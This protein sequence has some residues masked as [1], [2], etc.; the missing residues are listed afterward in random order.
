AN[1]AGTLQS[2]DTIN[3][4]VLDQA[5][6]SYDSFIFTELPR[7]KGSISGFVYEDKNTNFIKDSSEDAGQTWDVFLYDSEN[8]EI[9]RNTSF[10]GS[11]QPI[12]TNGAFNFDDLDLGTYV[13][14]ANISFSYQLEDPD[15]VKD[16]E[17]T[18]E[19][20]EENLEFMN[21]NFGGANSSRISGS[22]FVEEDQNGVNEGDW[23]FL[24]GVEFSLIGTDILGEAVNISTLSYSDD[25]EEEYG[26]FIFNN[27]IAG[28]YTITQTQPSEY[29]DGLDYLG[30]NKFADNQNPELIGSINDEN[31]IDI[32]LNGSNLFLDFYRFTELPKPQGSIS[33]HVY[34]DEN[35]DFEKQP[36]ERGFTTWTVDLLDDSSNVIATDTLDSNSQYLFEGL[37]L[38]TYTVI[39]KDYQDYQTED[40]D[41]TR[42]YQTTLEITT[43]NLDYT[44]VDFGTAEFSDVVG[45]NY[46]EKDQDGVNSGDWQVIGEVE[47]TLTGTDIFGNSVSLTTQSI[48]N[49]SNNNPQGSFE[50]INLVG[51]TYSITQTHPAEYIDGRDYLGNT[52]TGAVSD[53]QV[54]DVG[55]QQSPDTINDIV[56]DT[57]GLSYGPA[58]FTELPRPKGSISGFVYEDL[59]LNSDFTSGEFGQES[60]KVDLLDSSNNLVNTESIGID[61][62]YLFENLDLGTYTVVVKDYQ[63]YQ[64]EDPDD[65]RDYQTTLEITTSTLEYTDVDFGTA[66][67]NSISGINFV[68]DDQDGIDEGD[69]T[70]LPNIKMNI[71]GT[72]LSGNSVSSETNTNSNGQFTF[73]I[74][75]GGSYTISQT[76]PSEYEDGLDYII[77]EF[78]TRSFTSQN[79]NLTTL[80]GN[81]GNDEISNIN[82]SQ[83]GQ[84]FNSYRFTEIT[85]LQPN[86]VTN[87]VVDNVEPEVGDTIEVTITV[88]N[89]DGEGDLS[90]ITITDILPPELE[91][92]NSTL[93]GVDGSYNPNTDT[94]EIDSTLPANSSPSDP[95]YIVGEL[96]ISATVKELPIGG[97]SPQISTVNGNPAN[98]TQT[99][100]STVQFTNTSDQESPLTPVISAITTTIRSG[101]A[102]L[103]GFIAIAVFGMIGF[104][105]WK[106]T[107]TR[108]SIGIDVVDST[109]NKDL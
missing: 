68:E 43:S 101:G 9:T 1:D 32:T 60:W 4:I 59:N 88:A 16:Y 76:Q 19:I 86:I 13:V 49:D 48:E 99:Q 47:Y 2:P 36:N 14:K 18:I 65:T 28:T 20:T 57:T 38:G 83:S 71:V 52:F 73:N 30:Y 23:Q 55:T 6:M 22:T 87:I 50:F 92:T 97:I 108:S 53:I 3:D 61:S 35:L 37:D 96:T 56:L 34:L 33:G 70:A 5:G 42:D 109:E 21:I 103:V 66:R 27:L 69:Q 62:Q 54:S 17:T 98:T 7:P 67:F 105:V 31:S 91:Y 26:Y 44:E 93:E 11:G 90:D 25:D 106:K 94:L 72:D 100:P 41:D 85:I 45:N 74:L 79:Q 78:T 107:N 51:G 81:L 46:V 39:A 75:A 40:P 95:D 80:N 10:R 58:I 82:F 64:I 8:N 77:P 84:V 15:S 104:G 102:G 24:D 63:D 29:D 89:D 12:E